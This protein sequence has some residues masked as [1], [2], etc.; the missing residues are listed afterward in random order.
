MDVRGKEAFLMA[1]TYVVPQVQVFQDFTTHAQA[2]AQPLCAHIAGGHAWLTRYAQSTEK[3]IGYLGFYDWLN[4]LAYAWPQRPAG[5]IVDESY[6]KLYIDD[7]LLKYFED[8]I[9]SGS[10][11]QTVASHVNRIRSA[12]VNFVT[13]G[14]TYPRDASLFDRDVRAGDIAHVRAVVGSDTYD[15]WTYVTGFDG[16]ELVAVIDA[17][18]ADANNAATQVIPAVTHSQTAGAEN[19]VAITAHDSTLYDGLADGD[20]N[21]TYT[22]RVLESSAGGIATTATLQIVS[23]SGNDDVAEV[24]PAAFGSPTAIGTRGLT[25]TF[26][27]T[28]SPTCSLSA[29]N[30]GVSPDDFIVGQTWEVECGQ[31]YDE[32]TATSAGT[33]TGTRDCTYII[34]VIKGGLW[35]DSPQVSVSTDIGIDM[36]A[37][38]TFTSG[39]VAKAIGSFGVTLSFDQDG[40]CEGD[41]FYIPVHAVTEGPIRTLVLGHNFA[42]EVIANGATEVDLTL[43]IRKNI[44]VGED[45]IGFAPLTNWEQSTTEI[46]V[47]SGIMAYDAT[48]TDGGVP[49]P[50]EVFSEASVNYGKMYVEYRAWRADLCSIVGSIFDVGQ[51]ND[52]ISGAL[53]PD[54]P[55][56]WGVYKALQNSNGVDVKF[57]AVCDPSD[58]NSWAEVL[59]LVSDDPAI[60]GMVPLTR[61]ATVL[62]LYAAHVTSMSAPANGRWRVAWFNGYDASTKVVVNAAKSTDAEEVLAVLEDDPFTSGTQY[63]M[64][65]VPAANGQFVVNGVRA[66]DIVRYLYTTDGFGTVSYTEFVVDRVLNEDTLRLA[67]GNVTDV[68]TPRKVEVWRELTLTEQATE[69]A[70]QGGFSNSRIRY[71]WPDTIGEGAVEMEGYH[72]CAALAGLAGGVVPQQGLTRVAIVGFDDLSRTRMFS[73]SQLNTLSG[74]GVWVVDITPAGEVFSR[75]ALTTADYADIDAREEMVVR[76]VDSMS[77]YFQ[78]SLDPYIGISNITPSLIALIRAELKSSI[79]YLKSNNYRAQLGG[80]LI[81]AEIVEVRPHGTILDRLVV[82][83]GLTI[84]RATNNIE[85]HLVI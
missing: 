28:G 46:T 84:P 59:D 68:A 24:T 74:G 26:N 10:D 40:L 53:T 45:R 61:D 27:N 69:I 20:I 11:I 50:L 41:I 56:K 23:T 81:D 60:Y 9:G 17:A 18:T 32:P 12:T 65:R 49:Q 33:Y 39:G 5:G 51:L 54:N 71:V 48:W 36:S 30:D 70:A 22:V 55:L 29:E 76:N 14:V 67:T 44:E 80:Q 38:V 19:C 1:T 47:N 73:R 64:L 7:A 15:L 57:T 37:A 77:Y 62:G 75:H 2:N 13:N 21:E 83:L 58:P 63:T 31:A 85:C 16:D 43:F 82:V 4:D 42:S 72:L 78:A 25:V 79:A 3:S 6:T 66:G 52:S 35:A 34:E 8:F